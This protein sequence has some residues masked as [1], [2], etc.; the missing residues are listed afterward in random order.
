MMIRTYAPYLP[1]ATGTMLFP[2]L[3]SDSAAP[4]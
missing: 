2:A 4:Q 3:S 1:A